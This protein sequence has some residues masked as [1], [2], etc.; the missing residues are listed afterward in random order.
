M[1]SFQ[2]NFI[3][4]QLSDISTSTLHDPPRFAI[5]RNEA[6]KLCRWCHADREGCRTCLIAQYVDG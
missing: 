2:L 1:L 6:G 3:L 4:D 5:S